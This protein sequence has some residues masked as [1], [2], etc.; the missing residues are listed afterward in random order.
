MCGLSSC[1]VN[2]IIGNERFESDFDQIRPQFYTL[3]NLRCRQSLHNKYLSN[4]NNGYKDK[5]MI[6]LVT[7]ASVTTNEQFSVVESCCLFDIILNDLSR[8]ETLFLPKKNKIRLH[9]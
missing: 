7:A 3:C 5:A 1:F 9:Q 8:G 6:K 4:A 2:T